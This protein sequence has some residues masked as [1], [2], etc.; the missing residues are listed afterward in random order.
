MSHYHL[1]IKSSQ[2]LIVNMK[3]NEEI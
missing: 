3:D 2:A 1:N